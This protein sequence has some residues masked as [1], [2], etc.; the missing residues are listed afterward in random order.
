MENPQVGANKPP[1]FAWSGEESLPR[2]LFAPTNG[3]CARTRI[4]KTEKIVS[5]LNIEEM[6][7]R[8]LA[9]KARLEADQARLVDHSGEGMSQRVGELSNFDM[10]H[11]G[12]AGSEMFE[13]EK[14]GALIENVSILLGQVNDALA[15]IEE[16]TYGTCDRCK[17]PISLGRL[18]AHP[19]ATLCIECQSR[20]ENTL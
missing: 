9:E 4:G 3:L 8:I 13:R 5:K 1:R 16:G 6:R 10:N 14:D 17:R 12:D 2:G 7:D 20:V 15:K 19:Y 18:E 11:P